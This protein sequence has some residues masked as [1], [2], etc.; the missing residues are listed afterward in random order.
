MPP[1]NDPILIDID[2]HILHSFGTNEFKRFSCLS[3]DI[4]EVFSQEKTTIFLPHKH[5]NDIV[6]AEVLLQTGLI[7]QHNGVSQLY[8]ITEKSTNKTIGMIELISPRGAQMHY[9]LEQYPYFIEFC[10]SD[11]HTGK[12]IMS[13]LL[14]KLL[15]KLRQIGINK[16][17]AVAHPKNNSAIRV[18]NKSGLFKRASFDIVQD[19]YHN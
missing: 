7:N 17:G 16:I 10:L 5:L 6:H 11:K 13:M 15:D 1:S 2:E 14:P 12:G 19:V 18:L 3:R 4:F 9:N 8:F